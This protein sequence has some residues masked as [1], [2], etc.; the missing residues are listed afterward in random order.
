MDPSWLDDIDIHIG[1]RAAEA[2][3]TLL[4]TFSTRQIWGVP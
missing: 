2:M 4:A 3:H 1:Y